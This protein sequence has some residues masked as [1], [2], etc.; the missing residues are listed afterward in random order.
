MEV[1]RKSTIN[2]LSQKSA[3]FTCIAKQFYPIQFPKYDN[4]FKSHVYVGIKFEMKSIN[5]LKPS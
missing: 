2:R 1:L 3:T 4:R 5:A